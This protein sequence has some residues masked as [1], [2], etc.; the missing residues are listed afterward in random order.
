MNRPV[1]LLTR[2]VLVLVLCCLVVPSAGAQKKKT[3][4]ETAPPSAISQSP[5][6]DSLPGLLFVSGLAMNPTFHRY[7]PVREMIPAQVARQ[8]WGNLVD[9]VSFHD[10]WLSRGLTDFATSLYHLAGSSDSQD[11]LEHWRLARNAILGQNVYGMNRNDA[12][13]VWLGAMADINSTVQGYRGMVRADTSTSSVISVRKG[14]FVLHMLRC[15]MLDPASGDT[16]FIALMHDFVFTFA[17][18]GASTEDFKAIVEKHMKPSMDLEGNGKMDWFFNQWIYRKELP[19][20]RLEYYLDPQPDGTYIVQGSLTQSGVPESFVMRIP[21]YAK[22]KSKVVKIGAAVIAGSTTG[23]FQVTL[24]EAP[25]DILLNVRY[26]V[27]T[28]NQEVKQ[29]RPAR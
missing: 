23:K 1:C 13:P 12:A 8:W 9:P 5:A 28:R 6:M 14:G 19:S 25:K 17:H 26:E 4:A 7:F 2:C 22:L 20:Y 27:L 21:I 29:L 18:R 24:P 3:P 15:L 16:D 11:F 10:A